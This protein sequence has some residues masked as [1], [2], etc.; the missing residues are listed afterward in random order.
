MF[1]ISWRNKLSIAGSCLFASLLLG[2]TKA[3]AEYDVKSALQAYDA[4]DLDNRKVWDLIFGNT[5]NGMRWA[6]TF[7]V[8]RKQEQLFCEPS[9]L[10]G[11]QVTEML[12]KQMSADP[13]IGGVPFGLAILIVL[14]INFPCKP[15][16]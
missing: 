5:Y 15:E 13:K 4:A 9:V 11:P 1:R 7:L 14:Q 8:Q 6:N 10:S 2:L 12:R 16:G 3:S